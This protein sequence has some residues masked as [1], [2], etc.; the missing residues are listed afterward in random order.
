MKI[1]LITVLFFLS[2]K[3]TAE[4][5]ISPTAEVGGGFSATLFDKD[6][7]QYPVYGI[8]QGFLF[9]LDGIGASVK[10]LGVGVTLNKE[11][12]FIVVPAS[13]CVDKTYCMSPHLSSDYVGLGF[14]YALGKH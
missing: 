5:S 8:A 2:L 3:A 4:F 13:I 7:N 11:V 9:K 6:Y 10:F 14:T 1:V 12:D